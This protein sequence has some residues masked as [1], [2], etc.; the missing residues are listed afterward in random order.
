MSDDVY[1]EK[2]AGRSPGSVGDLYENDAWVRAFIDECF[3]MWGLPC[4]SL[5]CHSKAEKTMFAWGMLH[6]VSTLQTDPED[7]WLTMRGKMEP[8]K[9]AWEYS[10][11][12][13][14]RT[15]T[16]LMPGM[17]EPVEKPTTRMQLGLAKLVASGS[18]GVS[19]ASS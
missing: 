16:N 11:R 7:L 10:R 15:G 17:P 2:G 3:L 19:G 9:A 18:D 5:Q 14:E 8:D 12:F 6:L 4:S 1:K 13:W